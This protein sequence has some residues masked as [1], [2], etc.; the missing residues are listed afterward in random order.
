MAKLR[1]FYI[2]IALCLLLSISYG[3]K[4][5]QILLGTYEYHIDDRHEWWKIKLKSDSTFIH[6]NFSLWQLD[7]T[8]HQIGYVYGRWKIKGKYIY[9]YQCTN[10]G[11]VPELENSRWKYKKKKLYSAHKRYMKFHLDLIN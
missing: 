1:F 9:F 4:G 2:T 5:K 7:S 8:H 11:N 3:Q 6:E 10:Q